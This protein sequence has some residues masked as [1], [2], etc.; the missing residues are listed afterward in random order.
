MTASAIVLAGGRA[1][2]FGSDKRLAPVDGRPMLERVL[3]AVSDVAGEIIVVAEPGWSIPSGASPVAVTVSVVHDRLPGAGPLAALAEGLRAASG[4]TVL[5]VAG[6]M[7]WIVPAVL[8]LLRDAAAHDGGCWA[9]EQPG[10][11]GREPILPFAGPTEPL[12]DAVRALLADGARRLGDP[13]LAMAAR[14]VAADAWLA[15]DPDARTIDDVDRP[16]D[17]G[18]RT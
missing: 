8:A 10:S 14:R 4:Q 6:D 11:A 3:A 17:L 5:V 7:P 9:L 16:E 1:A 18:P 2:R 12:R 15:L 13:L